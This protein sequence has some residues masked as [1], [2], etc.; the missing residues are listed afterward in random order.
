MGMLGVGLSVYATSQ[1]LT[2]A[3]ALDRVLLLRAPVW[4]MGFSSGEEKISAQ[5][6]P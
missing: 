4:F 6:F 3:V 1:L 5:T 2:V